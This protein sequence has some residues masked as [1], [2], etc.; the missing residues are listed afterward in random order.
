MLVSFILFWNVCLVRLCLGDTCLNL[1]ENIDIPYD[2]FTLKTYL[3]HSHLL[4]KGFVGSN[5]LFYVC[6]WISHFFMGENVLKFVR[7][8]WCVVPKGWLCGGCVR[9]GACVFLIVCECVSAWVCAWLGVSVAVCVCVRVCVLLLVRVGSCVCVCVPSLVPRAT[10]RS[11][12]ADT[13]VCVCVFVC[14]CVWIY[15][16]FGVVDVFWLQTRSGCL[17]ECTYGC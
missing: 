14:V 9:A 15:T 6:A 12:H 7:E 5:F 13:C 3:I 11:L 10:P 2:F 4:R 1:L 16:G 8:C 17:Y